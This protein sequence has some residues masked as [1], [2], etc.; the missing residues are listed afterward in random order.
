MLSNLPYHSAY[1]LSK[2]K[3]ALESILIVLM[4]LLFGR[5][6]MAQEPSTQTR[7]LLKD[8][9][10]M[11][12]ENIGIQ[13]N[14]NEVY[15]FYEN[16]LFRWEIDG[17]SK[18][19]KEAASTYN[20]STILHLVPLHQ[21]IPVSVLTTRIS[22]FRKLQR[23]TTNYAQ[24]DNPLQVSLNSDAA[25]LILQKLKLHN[26]PLRKIDI[27]L[28]PGF[29]IQLGN[30]DNPV[31]W[32]FSIS[33]VVQ[34]SL[35][36]G[37]LLSA[38]VL[39]PLHNS[40]QQQYEGKIRLEAATVNQMFRLP[41]NLFIYTSAGIFPFRNKLSASANFQ[42]Y[43]ISTDLKKCFLNGRVSAGANVGLTGYL[44]INSGYL[45]YWPINRINFAVYA[46]YR[47]P[48]FDFTARLTAGKF[49]YDDR[50]VRLDISRQFHETS[51]GLFVIKSDLRSDGE[52][53]TV[54]GISLSIPIA[55]RK[56]FKPSHIRVNMA[57]YFNFEFRERTIDPVATT[58]RTNNDW[59]EIFSNLNPDFTREQL[60]VH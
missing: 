50:A 28:L 30:F 43:G 9:I 34:T 19:L 58:F 23:D 44:D 42:R 22:T 13:E 7:L 36:K 48:H 40:L 6:T 60:L 26:S 1:R 16:R 2:R 14:K 25:N 49:L 52:L 17:L 12:F 32:R 54:G 21:R 53:G 27:F 18:I 55:P 10:G 59:N 57:K 5:N 24:G 11:G 15:L 45:N 41:K 46:E 3:L 33:P 31:E 37:N 8:L 35:W 4:F 29:R 56:S 51:L 38:E 20:D 47:E 39:I